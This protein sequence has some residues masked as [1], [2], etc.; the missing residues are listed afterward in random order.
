MKDSE[1]NIDRLAHNDDEIA[2]NINH[3][4]ISDN[5]EMTTLESNLADQS[6]I[7]ESS[8][9]YDY[10]K[11][12]K[13]ISNEPNADNN[14]NND[15]SSYIGLS[16]NDISENEIPPDIIATDSIE[17]ND[18]MQEDLKKEAKNE[19]NDN[20]EDELKANN[21]IFID[22]GQSIAENGL[23]TKDSNTNFK[24]KQDN[25]EVLFTDNTNS[26]KKSKK[27]KKY[28]KAKQQKHKWKYII[29]SKRI[30]TGIIIVACFA[31]VYVGYLLFGSTS[32]EVLWKLHQTRNVLRSDVEQSRLD[33][34]EL[35]RK[36]LELK[37]LE[38]K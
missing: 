16:D 20:L 25:T 18:I 9:V 10:R 1:K 5:K 29:Y 34:A 15:T 12:T 11:K 19:L 21:D 3:P 2:K 32:F 27:Q 36:V 7:T 8:D 38:P 13:I 6:E 24:E 28:K 22:E 35:Q 4:Q 30:F 26:K 37:A 31:A 17:S 33:N 23:Q 14:A